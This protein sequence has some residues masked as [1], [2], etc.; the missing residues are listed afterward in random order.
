M[1][2]TVS[3]DFQ[4]CFILTLF[5]LFLTLFLFVF[6]FKKPK[7]GFDLPPSPPSLPII[8]HLHLLL[9]APIHKCFHKISS[10]YGPFLHLRIFHVPIVLVSSASMAHEIFKS[11]D[12]Y[13][14]FRGAVA[15]DECIVFGSFGFLR[16]PYGGY[17]RLIKK[18]ITTK[19]IGPQALERSHGVRVIELERFYKNLLDKAMKKQSVEIG[20]EAMRLVNNTLGKLS[21][22][23]AFSVED[24]D[25]GKVSEFTVK[26]SALSRTFFVAQIFNEPLE[27]LGISLLKKEI[28]EVSHRFE[29]LL[30]KT[31]VRYEEEMDDHQGTEFMDTLM[32]AYRDEN[33][34]YKITRKNIKAL[35]AE[36]FFGAG[37]TSSTTTRWAMAEIIN[38]P[39]ILEKLREEIDS[40]VGK[41]RIVQETD[42]PKLPYLQAVVK[43]TLRLHP[44]APVL[45]R[46]F[47]QGC[48][49]GR[50]YIPEGTSLVINAYAVMRDPDSWE[51]PNEFK[52][53]RFLASSRSGQEEERREQALKFLAFGTGRRGCP[54]SSLA[55]I[56]VGT[57]V[58]VMVQCFDWEINGDNVNME[59]ATGLKFFMA[60]A[61]PLTCRPLPRI[62]NH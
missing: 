6:F 38:N 10:K 23:S 40:V 28:M 36:L 47:E 7:N 33:A 60:L 12:M 32:A 54:G 61:N 48:K 41:T 42:L 53:E 11:H 52:P 31:L 59:E 3:F 56:L 21:M 35:F 4:N 13:V 24:N 26:L 39:K 46:E 15:I 55:Y 34:E 43:E 62:I 18:I 44:V 14:S 1:A 45:S 51:D 20:E 25:G 19:G 16:A 5:C 57:A 49:I 58:G 50:F 30:E 27:K 37:D 8:G 9:L 2:A 17:W 22:G 29:E